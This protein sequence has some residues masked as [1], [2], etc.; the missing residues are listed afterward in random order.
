MQTASAKLFCRV[1][2][3]T[4]LSD[5]RASDLLLPRLDLSA[6]F[7]E[8][9]L[10]W[11][12]R[13]GGDVRLGARVSAIVNT[14]RAF[15]IDTQQ[16]PLLAERV[17]IACGPRE[18]ATLLRSV[19]GM[20]ALVR[21]LDAI[22]Y[23]SIHSVYIR[24][25]HP[26]GLP[27]PMLGLHEHTAQWLFDRQAL[28]GQTGLLGAVISATGALRQQPT[29]AVTDAV[30]SECDAVL[31]RFGHGP[32]APLWTKGVVEKFATFAARPDLQRPAAATGLPGLVLAG[33]YV[34]GPYPAT[35]E[36]AVR[37]GIYAAQRLLDERR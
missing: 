9:A 30:V 25:P 24:Y 5:A 19:P 29:Q 36:G 22:T 10:A 8:P 1:L 11:V 4:L 6:L 15:E 18:A 23:E 37:S 28:C 7:P 17:I 13:R 12:A 3:D 14:R 34:D 35:L 21:C 26:V 20:D 33:D 2:A 31:R 16:G 27:V 32:Q